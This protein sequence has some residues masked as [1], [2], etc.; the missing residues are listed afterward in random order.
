MFTLQPNVGPVYDNCSATAQRNPSEEQDDL[1]YATV[2]F[3][4]NQEDPLYSNVG[5]A[6]PK[7]QQHE[8]EEEEE[9]E[10]GVEY[11]FVNFKSSSSS[12]EWVHEKNGQCCYRHHLIAVASVDFKPGLN[13][14]FEFIYEFTIHS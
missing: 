8:E 7:R 2:S 1:N 9:D 4:K 3:S 10:D 11:T 6:N 13:Q 5:L 12:P 14:Y